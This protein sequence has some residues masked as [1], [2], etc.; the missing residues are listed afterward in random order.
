MIMPAEV[1]SIAYAGQRPWHGLGFEITSAATPEEMLRYAKLDW[2]VSKRPI[3]TNDSADIKNPNTAATLLFNDLYALVRD[4]DNKIL[5]V[6]GPNYQPFQNSETM[7]FFKKFCDAGS[8]T[9]EVAGSLRG[10]KWVW[11]LA[12]I[13]ASP[14]TLMGEDENYTYLLL[15]SPHIWGEAATIMF[16]SVRVVCWNTLTQAMS[17]SLT[18]KFRLLHTRSF[19]DVRAAAELTVEQTLIQKAVYEQKIKLLAE[20]PL[21]DLTALYNYIAAVMQPTGCRD[22]GT[23]LSEL[24]KPAQTVL[25]NYHTAPGSKLQSASGT[26]WG[27]FNAITYYYDHQYGRSG[28]DN[29]LYE[30]WLSHKNAVI[31]RKAFDIALAH[32]Q[33]A[34]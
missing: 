11:A 23:P 18:D 13:A 7:D 16:T 19:Q 30:A 6:C 32:A 8:M 31:K 2:T 24:G 12:R 9:M 22:K 20:T 4:S 14:F 25:M 27:A 17:K 10:G 5:G 3:W 34:A 1:E 21:V 15:C 28:A 29:R 33:A 26:Y